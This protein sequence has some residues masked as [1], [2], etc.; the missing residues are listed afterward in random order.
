M[1]TTALTRRLDAIERDRMPRA[2]GSNLVIRGGLPGGI[3]HAE[4]GSQIWLRCPGED[5]RVFMRRVR[6]AAGVSAA[7]T[8][9]GLPDRLAGLDG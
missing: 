9:G 8:W 4:A 3:T 6:V 7:I 1:S 2:P 5:E